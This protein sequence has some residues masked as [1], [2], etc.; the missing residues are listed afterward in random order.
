MNPPIFERASVVIVILWLLQSLWGC[1]AAQDATQGPRTRAA[2]M[3][4]SRSELAAAALAARIYV[5]GGIA[6]WGTT[7]AF[8]AYDP[9]TNRWEELPPLPEAAHHLAAAATDDRIYVTGG[10]TNLL[11]TEITKRAW[12][13]DPGARRWTG[14]ADLPGP[15]AAHGMAAIEDR[16]YVVGGVGPASEE[17]WVYDPASDRWEAAPAPLSTRR[18]HL[19]VTVLDGKLYAVG[20]RWGNAGNLA[21]LEIY[22]AAAGRW[23]RG[24]DLPTPRS[25]LTAGMLDGNVHVTGGESLS[26][27]RTFGEHE[28]YDPTTARWTA[29]ASLPTPRHGLTSAVVSGRWYVIGGGTRAGAMTFISLADLVEVFPGRSEGAG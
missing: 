12:A 20:G 15:R 28:A 5:A 7:A 19:A 14:I 21:A 11:F 4:T 3:P 24:P 17:I 23:T 18:E 6:Q 25:G 27:D 1:A 29:L 26:L 2:P 16:L 13:Y 9:T 8:E 10:Y 22:D